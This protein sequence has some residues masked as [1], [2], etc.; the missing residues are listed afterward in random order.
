MK[1]HHVYGPPGTGKTRYIADQIEKNIHKFGFNNIMVSSFTK[2]AAYE[3]QQ[4]SIKL[5]KNNVGTLHSIC[6]RGLGKPDIAEAKVAEFNETNRWQI[7]TR[8]SDTEEHPEAGQSSLRGDKMLERYSLLRNRME[9]VDEVASIELKGFAV[10]WEAWKEQNG[11][12]DFCD[13]IH[14]G[15]ELNHAPGMPRIGFID[16]AQDLSA[17]EFSLVRTWAERMEQVVFVGD[18]DQAIYEWTGAD[19]RNLL[20]A[21]AASTIVL[22]RSYR[23]PRAVHRVASEFI[24]RCK[25]RQPKEFL[26]RDADGSAVQVGLRADDRALSDL[27]RRETDE[28]RTVMILATC[29]YMLE[30]PLRTLRSAGISYYNPYRP[31]HGRWNPFRIGHSSTSHKLWCFLQ[32]KTIDGDGPYWTGAQM[33]RWISLCRVSGLFPA[34]HKDKLS[35]LCKN[36]P[37]KK[38]GPTD[39]GPYLE[40]VP[41]E[42]LANW[43]NLSCGQRMNWLETHIEAKRAKPFSAAADMVRRSPSGE[44]ILIDVPKVI[45]GTIHSVKGAEADTVIMLPDIS[46]QALEMA[47]M[48]STVRDGLICAS[49]ALDPLLRVAYVGMTRARQNLIVLQPMRAAF[50]IPY[51]G[52]MLPMT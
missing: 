43:P 46:V 5:A 2:T 24:A 40:S 19:V 16:E 34:K 33:E 9:S 31:A 7:S 45:V 29:G 8:K 14:A 11:Y 10:A 25:R 4:R 49:E 39:W 28:G 37:A 48:G 38:F 36:Q 21:E 18:D 50:K 13:L 47:T 17:L 15:K 41:R 6:W 52:K 44:K 27:V 35:E 22:K 32:G 3:I 42:A 30:H 51:L 1:E 20:D 12:M 23:L 26:C